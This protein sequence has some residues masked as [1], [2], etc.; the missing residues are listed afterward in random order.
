VT[1]P[2]VSKREMEMLVFCKN[3]RCGEVVAIEQFMAAFKGAETIPR[4]RGGRGATWAR[5]RLRRAS[6]GRKRWPGSCGGPAG[7]ET[8][9]VF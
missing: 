1:L 8:T 6:G 3:G 5:E 7:A 4:R 9:P 2:L